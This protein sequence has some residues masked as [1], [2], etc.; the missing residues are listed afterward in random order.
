MRRSLLVFFFVSSALGQAYSA[1]YPY[2]LRLDHSSFE[3]HSCALLQ[4]TGAFHLEVDSGDDV[5]VFE[6]V[7]PKDQLSEIQSDLSSNLLVNLSQ[8]QIQEPLIRTRHDELQ[9]TVFRGG[10]LQDLYFRSSDS[11][12][13][14]KQVLKPLVHRLDSSR[15]LSNRELSED[16]GKNNCLPPKAIALRR[17]EAGPPLQPLTVKTT[18][19]ILSAERTPQARPSPPVTPPS[20]SALLRVYFFESK[21]S[22]AHESCALVA[23]NREYRFEDR[24]QKT[25]NPV[26]TK[27]TAGQITGEQLQ[28][29]KQ[30]LDDPAIKA[31]KHREPAGS[32]VIP[33][34]GD[35]LQLSISRPTGT[36]ELVLSSAY[37]RPGMPAFYRGDGDLHDAD[38]L[39]KFLAEHVEGSEGER[40]PKDTRT[41]C[42]DTP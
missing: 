28:Q 15:K 1:D 13:P 25:G 23:D 3:G 30:I 11:Q 33:M 26:D 18:R 21:T 22:S 19:R 6:G 41:G 34:F 20:I 7:I 27:I 40:L 32:R 16:E 2:L 38:R 14:F 12:L 39:L 9:V 24:T 42:A 17:R 8:A 36:Q 35:M 29:L 31:I 37:K 4:N 5:K 10:A